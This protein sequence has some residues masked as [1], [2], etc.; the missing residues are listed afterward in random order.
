MERV[1]AREEGFREAVQRS[2]LSLQE[3]DVAPLDN[4][5]GNQSQVCGQHSDT[6][7]GDGSLDQILTTIEKREILGA[8]RRANGQRTLA[9][10]M[11]GISRSRLYRRMEALGIDPRAAASGDVT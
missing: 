5:T 8:L 9:A 1:K 3:N 7:T 2:S 4:V 11:L 6:D 10:R